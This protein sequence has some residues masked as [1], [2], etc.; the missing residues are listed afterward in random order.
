M[1]QVQK[2]RKIVGVIVISLVGIIIS[3]LYLVPTQTNITMIPET[4]EDRDRYEALGIAQR[5]ITTTSTFAFDGDINTLDT[6]S[7]DSLET[8]PPQYLIKMAFESEHDGYGNRDGL[9]LSKINT[10]HKMEIIVSERNV[11][12]A[13]T[14][15]VWDEINNQYILKNPQSKLTSSDEVVPFDGQVNDFLS[16]NSALKSRGLNVKQITEISD[17]FFSVPVVVLTVG[18]AEIQTYEFPLA[19]DTETAKSIISKDG[20]QI[21]EY[22][23]RWIEP[24]HFYSNGKLIVQYIGK[25]PEI[26]SLLE[27]MLGSQFAGSL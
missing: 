20:S 1:S 4:Q 23:V 26:T 11:I 17:S 24:P 13:V 27:S 7:M 5:F 25:N 8:D 15:G 9:N 12:S 16:F 18:G 21:G 10:S 19:S 14:D 2:S 22:P 3:G 6:I